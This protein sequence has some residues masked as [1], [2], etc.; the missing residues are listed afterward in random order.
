MLVQVSTA[1]TRVNVRAVLWLYISIGKKRA[2]SLTHAHAHAHTHEDV[3][4][5][6]D[7][8]V[9]IRTFSDFLSALRPE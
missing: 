1:H 6:G 7:A 5:A 2:R 9:E 4:R 8:W 3:C